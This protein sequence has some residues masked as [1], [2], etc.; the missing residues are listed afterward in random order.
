MYLIRRNLCNFLPAVVAN[1]ILAHV[2]ALMHCKRVAALITETIFVKVAICTI[3]D[4]QAADIAMMRVTGVNAYGKNRAAV[5]ALVILAIIEMLILRI[6]LA[7]GIAVVISVF[8]CAT[9]E[10]LLAIFANV[11]FIL[12][13]AI[14]KNCITNIASVILGLC[15]NAYGKNRAATIVTYVIIIVNSILT[16][17]KHF[18][19]TIITSVIVVSI[20]ASDSYIFVANIALMVFV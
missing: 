13:Y 12:V 5:V 17:A 3:I 9:A 19:A 18:V 20:L 6:G 4:S 15:V 2:Y 1:V 10:I 14:A 11:V 16:N 7:A 8:I